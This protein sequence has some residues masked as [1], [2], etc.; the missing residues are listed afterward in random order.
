MTFT[1]AFWRWFGQSKVVDGQGHPKV[2]YHG[3]G[4]EEDD[5]QGISTSGL[6]AH[7][8]TRMSAETRMWTQHIDQE[9]EDA[10]IWEED[11]RYFLDEDMWPMQP[12]RGFKTEEK[13]KTFIAD[14]MQYSEGPDDI[15]LTEAFL[16]IENPLTLQDL[17]TWPFAGIVRELREMSVFSARDADRAYDAYNRS[18]AKG[19]QAIKALLMRKGFDGIKYRNAVEDPGKFSYIIFKPTQAKS[20][21]NRGTWDQKDPSMMNPIPKG[22]YKFIRMFHWK[23]KE[24]IDYRPHPTKKG[25]V[26]R[27][28]F[29]IDHHV[30]PRG[31]KSTIKSITATKEIRQLET[32]G[33]TNSR[34]NPDRII[35]PG[36]TYF[37]DQAQ[38]RDIQE[39]VYE[40]TGRWLS[41]AQINDFLRAA[42][43]KKRR[44]AIRV[45][46]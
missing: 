2:M 44:A 16:R 7:F 41:P 4:F 15:Y 46:K 29:H 12:T 23:K 39:E 1:D 17:G 24:Y 40:M 14:Q 43:V 32:Q 35:R 19:Y 26:T 11:G 38:L 22:T 42:L 37:R 30:G 33:W 36:P 10:P 27:Q 8:G 3:G 13:A 6:G 28:R 9:I 20:V 34:R 45:V 18:D 21:N 5:P 25:Y 31:R